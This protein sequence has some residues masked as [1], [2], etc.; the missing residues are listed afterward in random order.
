LA[1]RNHVSVSNRKRRSV[2]LSLIKKLT[3][4]A[5]TTVSF[6]LILEI[7]LA[8]VG[9][10]PV[11]NTD[12]PFVGFSGYAPLM[13]H[14]TAEDGTAILTTAENKRNWF[15]IQSFPKV[16]APRTKRI[17]CMGGSTTYGHPFF[18]S[19]S[20]SGWLREYLPVHDPSCHWEVINAGGIS[21][22]SYRV[23][24][25]M[26]ELAQYE[27]DLFIVYSAHN[28]FLERRTYQDL[29]ERSQLTMFI[30]GLL[31]KTRTWAFTK[32]TFDQIRKSTSNAEGTRSKTHADILDTEVNEILNHTIGPVDY[33]RDLTWRAN[34]VNHYENNLRRMVAIARNAGAE[35]VFVTPA[36]NEKDCSPFKSEH[37]AQLSKSDQDRLQAI[38]HQ[39]STDP[40][41]S[42]PKVALRYLQEA[43]A[44]SPNFSE[45][46]YRI[47][48]LQLVLQNF[49]EAQRSFS[50]ALNE[51]V[52]PLRA[53]DEIR[54]SIDRVG[55][56][57]KAPVVDFEQ[58]IRGL[59]EMENG[60]SILG[61][62]YFLDHVH[63][64][65]DVNRRLAIW[66]I[67]TLLE[68][69]FVH[70]RGTDDAT[71]K[72]RFAAIEP[73][74]LGTID[75]VT[76]GYALRNLAKVLHWSGKFHEAESRARDALKLI[77]DD[78]ESRFVLADC[79]KNTGRLEEAADEYEELFAGGLTYPRAA[80]AYGRLLA[81]IGRLEQAKGYLLLA[82]AE[83][84]KN[85]DAYHWLGWVHFQ[86]REFDFA[87][88]SFE[89]A[90][91][92]R[93][94]N[95]ETIEYWTRSKEARERSL[96]TPEAR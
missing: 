87:V 6:F 69:G 28:E 58:Q 20:F 31:S 37:H 68:L 4:S 83:D 90:N 59:C 48:H 89:H 91:R 64:T 2:Q 32:R 14:S 47:G 63:P 5:F 42:D 51:D 94:N 66:I 30:Q 35:I 25:L 13:A 33:H 72:E 1:D 10:R 27:P 65:I 26:E 60:H 61:E 7:G 12:D 36:S 44:I 76:N 50:I 92:I 46:H 41:C 24:T 40:E 84:N 53:V 29:F 11:V 19:T 96:P 34:V 95:Q 75:P 78:P 43:V 15:N 67:E 80:E 17:F 38:I 49:S 73:K 9:I 52:C 88:E 93:P 18:D 77:A 82:I 57:L 85:A 74:V 45:Y 8:V 55:K 86:L 16:K 71:S 21:Y 39:A 70:G 62:E 81:T 22:A 56:E 79:L 3:L 23:A 54:Q